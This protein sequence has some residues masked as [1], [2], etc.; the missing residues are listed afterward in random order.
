MV[1]IRRTRGVILSISIITINLVILS[2]IQFKGLRNYVVDNYH[3]HLDYIKE[4]FLDNGYFNTE[5]K[6]QSG[7]FYNKVL[8]AALSYGGGSLSNSIESSFDNSKKFNQ[9]HIPKDI[10]NSY[11]PFDPRFTF[12]LVLKYLNDHETEGL[13]ELPAFHW[14]DYLD[15]STLEDR[16]FATTKRTCSSFDVRRKNNPAKNAADNIRDPA[17]YCI[18]DDQIED[19]LKNQK[20]KY[21]PYVIQTLEKISK[22]PISTGYHIYDF[23]G[24]NAKNN[25]PLLG[26]SYLYEFMKNPLTLVMLLPDNKKFQIDVNQQEKTKLVNS[27]KIY[28][29][30][31]TINLSDEIRKLS[32]KLPTNVPLTYEK[33]LTHDMFVDTTPDKV[34]ELLKQ[35]EPLSQTDKHYLESLQNSLAV[36]NPKKYFHEANLMKRDP[37][38]ALGGHY[39]WRFFNGIINDT[40]D[41]SISLHQLLKSWLRF[42]NHHGLNTWVA[43]GSLLSWY[44]NGLQFP[45]DTDIDVQ[46]PIQDLHKLSQMF[47]QSMIVDFGNDFDNIKFGRYFLDVSNIISQRT[48]GNGN[49]NIDAR[50]IDVETGLYI[51]ITGLAIS[52]SIAPIRYNPLLVGTFLERNNRDMTIS[53]TARNVYLEAYNCRNNHFSRLEELSPLTLSLIEGEFGYVP[54]DFENII[55]VEYTD[56]SMFDF[57]YRDFVFLPKLRNWVVKKPVVDFIVKK[58]PTKS[59]Q[60]VRTNVLAIDLDDD[61]YVEF[62]NENKDDMFNY[63]L[64]NNLTSVHSQQMVNFLKGRPTKAILFDHKTDQVKAELLTDLRQDLFKFKAL[65]SAYDYDAELSRIKSRVSDYKL[66]HDVDSTDE[67]TPEVTDPLDNDEIAGEVAQM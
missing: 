23:P 65:N 36:E 50:F 52:E 10:P 13:T 57:L 19:I 25:R 46:M 5:S 43:H 22:E 53:E 58:L 17:L 31:I 54:K 30:D 62:L 66:N 9:I 4:S 41:L 63:L 49:N 12:G 59:K 26:R 8:H 14:G 48:R 24:R 18:D 33:H 20:D 1:F 64:T 61:E 42:T 38:F 16:F 45:W 2:L 15:M 32:D 34:Q 35:Q 6:S 11:Q 55:A 60:R 21:D 40:P 7:E 51:D 47:N 67:G 56:K 27:P 39:D 28:S 29:S 37:R 44:W 3:T